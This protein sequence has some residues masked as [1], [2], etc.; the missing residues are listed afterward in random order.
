MAVLQPNVTQPPVKGKIG[1]TNFLVA[2][3]ADT[4]FQ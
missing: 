1:Y 4:E 3:E 2:G